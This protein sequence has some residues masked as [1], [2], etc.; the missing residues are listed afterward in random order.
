MVIANPIIF[1]TGFI[2]GLFILL[3]IPS[4]SLHWA[5]KMPKISKVLRRYHD[6]TLNIAVTFAIGNIFLVLA[7]FIFG[8]WL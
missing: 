8:I 4:C 3:H 6:E 7:G 5:D 1:W 2:S